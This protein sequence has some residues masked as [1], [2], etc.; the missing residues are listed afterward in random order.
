MYGESSHTEQIHRVWE[1]TEQRLKDRGM[2]EEL[3]ASSLF[4]KEVQP[5]Q[6]VRV[7]LNI[8]A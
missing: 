6:C 3:E 8:C 2:Q 4:Y 1:G 5:S 7:G